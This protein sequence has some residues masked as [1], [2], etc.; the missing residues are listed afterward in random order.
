MASVLIVAVVAEG[1]VPTSAAV[2]DRAWAASTDRAEECQAAST[3]QVAECQAASIDRAAVV[4]RALVATAFVQLNQRHVLPSHRLALALDRSR[5]WAERHDR[6]FR[7]YRPLVFHVRTQAGF[8]GRRPIFPAL[9][10]LTSAH[11]PR[12]RSPDRHGRPRVHPFPAPAL[13]VP[14]V[15]M[16]LSV[17]K[18]CR[19]VH[20]RTSRVQVSPTGRKRC[21]AVHQQTS[22]VRVSPSGRKHCLADRQQA[23][24]VRTYRSVRKR[25]LVDRQQALL[26]RTYRS[27]RKRCLADR[28]LALRVRVSPIVPVSRTVQDTPIDRAEMIGGVPAIP[29][30]PSIMIVLSSGIVQIARSSAAEI[31]ALVVEIS[32]STTTSTIGSA[33]R[34]GVGIRVGTQVG[35][36]GGIPV[37]TQVGIDHLGTTAIGMH[38]GEP[39]GIGRC[40]TTTSAGGSDPGQ[41]IQRLLTLITFHQPQPF[42]ITPNRS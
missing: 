12:C 3:G 30:A 5:R 36:R 9:V 20:R 10:I 2:P 32:I 1:H 21:R 18:H 25:C 41:R 24:L 17:R 4:C 14:R 31:W 35:T 23:L 16:F 29:T 34:T 27:G 37:G 33:T 11:V 8:S 40:Q 39:V 38:T 26:V 6:K 19:A 7:T 13:I 15:L 42:T 28:Q 22:R